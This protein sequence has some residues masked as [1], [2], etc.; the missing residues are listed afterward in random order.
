MVCIDLRNMLHCLEITKD[1]LS[2][3][4]IAADNNVYVEFRKNHCF[5]KD[6]SL[7]NVLLHDSIKDGLYLSFDTT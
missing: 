1:L 7:R 4:K 3:S 5:V 2:I 6:K